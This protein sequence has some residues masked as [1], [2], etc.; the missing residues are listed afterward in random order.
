MKYFRF[1]MNAVLPMSLC[2]SLCVGCSGEKGGDNVPKAAENAEVTT[3]APETVSAENSAQNLT[4]TGSV[5]KP[6][7]LDTAVNAHIQKVLKENPELEKAE[8]P[9]QMTYFFIRA[10]QMDNTP[11]V[12]GMLTQDAY[13]EMSARQGEKF[14]CPEFLKNSDVALGNVQY[15]TDDMSE[16]ENVEHVEN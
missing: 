9:I 7:E 15:L 14:P 6:A 11:A 16:G 4:A 3:T 2:L 12:M 10:L 13:R 5:R 1:C 8:A